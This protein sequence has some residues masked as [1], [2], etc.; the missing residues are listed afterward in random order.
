MLTKKLIIKPLSFHGQK[1]KISTH[2]YFFYLLNN[3][4]TKWRMYFTSL[5][6][7]WIFFFFLQDNRLCVHLIMYPMKNIILY[8][9]YEIKILN[10]STYEIYHS[11]G[12]VELGGGKQ[13]L[14]PT[15]YFNFFI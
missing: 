7:W 15:K 11:Y 1:H 6:K 2:F 4:L 8:H 12:G 9:R 5:C 10:K 13:G 3:Y 14:G